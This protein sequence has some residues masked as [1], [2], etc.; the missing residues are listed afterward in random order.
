MALHVAHAAVK[1]RVQP[2]LQTGL[3]ICEV[4]TRHA[5]LG[6]SQGS[7]PMAHALQQVSG[8]EVRRAVIHPPILKTHT[9]LAQ[10]EGD[11][12]ELAQAW[13]RQPAL[14]EAFI[15]LQGPL[16]A[17]KTTFTRHLLRALGFDGRVKSPT[18]ALVETYALPGLPIHH[19]DFY[20]LQD[21]QEWEDAGL[22]DLFAA[23][24]LKLVEWPE[25]AEGLL[26]L[27]DLDVRLRPHAANEDLRDVVVSAY[28]AVGVAVMS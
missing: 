17:G 11:L 2:R 18:Y 27:P 21:A 25:R 19:C 24:G 12:A 23:P 14:R 16:G 7:A 1:A 15:T 20:R 8:I 6:K 28:S 13:A 26:P 5:D 4:D 9:H 10:T 3:G 22:R